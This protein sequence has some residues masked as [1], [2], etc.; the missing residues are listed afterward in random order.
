[1]TTVRALLESARSSSLYLRIDAG[2]TTISNDGATIMNMLDI[3]KLLHFFVGTGIIQ[4]QLKARNRSSPPRR[5]NVGGHREVT[6]R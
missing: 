3:G 1:M 4:V 6:G 2:K 5:K